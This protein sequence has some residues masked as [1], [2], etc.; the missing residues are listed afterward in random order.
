MTGASQLNKEKG[1]KGHSK[2]RAQAVKGIWPSE[3]TVWSGLAM[4]FTRGAEKQ[5]G[6][7][8]E[9]HSKELGVYFGNEA[10]Q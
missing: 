2:Q 4:A 7:K 1:K 9:C 6:Y 3:H 10:K 5:R 8:N